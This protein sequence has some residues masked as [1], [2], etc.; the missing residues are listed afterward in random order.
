MKLLLIPI[1]FSF[2]FSCTPPAQHSIVEEP[3]VLSIDTTG[4]KSLGEGLKMKV[5]EE[6]YGNIPL[7]GDKIVTNYKG[8]FVNGKV[9]DESKNKPFTFELGGRVIDGWNLS[10]AHLKAGSKATV[11]VPYKLAYGEN[12]Y[13]TIPGKSDMIFEVHFL[14]IIKKK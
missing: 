13:S 5:T 2:L 4:F 14:E 7:E 3:I 12:D 10:F 8:M 9:F 11:Y 1:T 6:G